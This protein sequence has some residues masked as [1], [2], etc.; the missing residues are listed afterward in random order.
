VE[1]RA[2]LDVDGSPVALGPGDWLVLEA[3]VP[4]RVTAT[5]AGTRWLAVHLP[6]P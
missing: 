2:T 6:P 5:A 4:H 3:G 1:G